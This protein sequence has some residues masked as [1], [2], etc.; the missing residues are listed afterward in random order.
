MG[1]IPAAQRFDGL[2]NT[3][4]LISTAE[5][6][7]DGATNI[8][9]TNVQGQIDKFKCSVWSNAKS[10]EEIENLIS[11]F[12]KNTYITTKVSKYK[13]VML[14]LFIYLFINALN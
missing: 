14:S 1:S 3:Q 2:K 4:E 6:M 8:S 11:S 7:F 9:V 5:E 10:D 13:Y 12:E